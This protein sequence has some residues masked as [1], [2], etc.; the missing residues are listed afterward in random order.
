MAQGIENFF[1]NGLAAECQALR[2]E[3]KMKLLKT[4]YGVSQGKAKIMTTV[5]LKIL[6]S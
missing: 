5:H 6:L 4:I 2:V 3:E 1:I